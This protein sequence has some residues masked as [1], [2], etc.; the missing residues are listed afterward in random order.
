MKRVVVFFSLIALALIVFGVLAAS[1]LPD[2]LEYVAE[3]FGFASR[4]D[5]GGPASPFAGY[6][7]RALGSSW[8]SRVLAGLVGATLMALFGMGFGRLIQY[9]SK[10]NKRDALDR[11][12]R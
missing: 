11:E 12:S 8:S 9:G 5:E 10:R 6:E 3:V 1:S 4:A 2:G 7:T